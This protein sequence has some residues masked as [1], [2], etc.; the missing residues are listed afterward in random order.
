VNAKQQAIWTVARLKDAG[1]TVIDSRMPPR[2]WSDNA[3]RP[4]AVLLHHTAST[5]TT[6]KEQEN[7]DAKYIKHVPWG[8]PGAQF[9]VGRTGRIFFLCDGGAN[10]AGT[11]A[12]LTGH[13]IPADQGNYKMWGIEVQSAGYKKDWTKAQW[14]AVHYLT[15]Y[16][17]QAMDQNDASR[18]WRHKDYD[19]DSGKVDTVYPLKDHRVAVRSALTQ[20]Q[21]REKLLK[22]KGWLKRALDR[23]REKL[24][25]I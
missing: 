16:L 17:L 14:R 24:R 4:N 21:R 3:F 23:V 5:S 25:E 2:E 11:G 9:Y 15:A 6:S 10:H 13:G 7:A 12:A 19:D 20:T 1:F 8:G 18:V 22:R